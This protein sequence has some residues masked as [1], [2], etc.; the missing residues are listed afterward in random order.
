MIEYHKK[1]E[2][3]RDHG[4]PSRDLSTHG[5]LQRCIL[6]GL[7]CFFCITYSRLGSGDISNLGTPMGADTKV[8][9]K[10]CSFWWKE[11]EKRQSEQKTCRWS[12]FIPHKPHRKNCGPLPIPGGEPHFPVFA[13]CAHLCTRPPTWSRGPRGE[14]DSHTPRGEEALPP[15]LLVWCHWGPNREQTRGA[16]PLPSQNCTKVGLL[17]S[18]TSHAC[19]VIMNTP[20]LNGGWQGTWTSAL[21]GQYCRLN[22]YKSI[23][24]SK[25]KRNTVFLYSEDKTLNISNIPNEN[26]N[27]P[28]PV[29]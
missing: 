21:I 2:K 26:R 15:S 19:H 27:H 28:S 24:Q 12:C 3:W 9:R 22:S 16:P 23:R 1:T 29:Y 13:W 25:V 10:P 8:T 5:A 11:L 17:G 7:W 20:S 14:P 4:K 18:L 6:W